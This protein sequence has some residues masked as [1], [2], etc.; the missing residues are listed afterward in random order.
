VK[1]AE[2]ASE[3]GQPAAQKP[4]RSADRSAALALTLFVSTKDVQRALANFHLRKAA[5]N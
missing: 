5:N 2:P 4:S 1:V 3:L